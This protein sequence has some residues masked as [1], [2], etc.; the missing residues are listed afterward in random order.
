M[1]QY[2]KKSYPDE[3]KIN[4]VNYCVEH[5]TLEAS[6]EFDVPLSTLQRWCAEQNRKGGNHKQ[7]VYNTRKELVLQLFKDEPSTLLTVNALS[8]I[9]P[10]IS[11]SSVVK[12][13]KRFSDDNEFEKVYTKVNAPNHHHKMYGICL[14]RSAYNNMISNNGQSTFNK[15]KLI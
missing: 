14:S 12:L 8:Y 15:H 3:F 7:V 2:I 9:L 13:M 10:F 4:V 11:K 1:K 5:T 6:Y